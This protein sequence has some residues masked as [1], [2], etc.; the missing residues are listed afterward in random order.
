M[1]L[2]FDDGAVNDEL[3]YEKSMIILISFAM[4]ARLFSRCFSCGSKLACP[5]HSILRDPSTRKLCARLAQCASGS[6]RVS[7]ELGGSQLLGLGSSLN[8]S[9]NN[10]VPPSCLCAEVDCCRDRWITWQ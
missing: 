7:D 4:D 5:S 6:V 1:G 2:R 3:S 9:N 10:G 8:R